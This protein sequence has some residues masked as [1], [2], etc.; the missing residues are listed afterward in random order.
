MVFANMSRLGHDDPVMGR[1][2]GVYRQ[3]WV[4]GR[5]GLASAERVL[6]VFNSSS[7]PTMV[8]KGM[9]LS[10]LYYPT[11][12][13][14]PMNDIDVLV[15]RSMVEEAR[16]ALSA[17]GWRNSLLDSY[18][19]N[20]LM[21]QLMATRPGIGLR[22]VLGR[23]VDLHWSPLHEGGRAEFT[24]WFWRCAEPMTLGGT[25]TLA[26]GPVR[27]LL[28]V[29]SHGLRPDGM[30][31]SRL[32]WVVDATMI[33]RR[34]GDDIDWA[35]FWTMARLARVE[36]RVSEGLRRL[37]EISPVILPAGARHY[38]R[39]SLIE[40]LERPLL[41]HRGDVSSASLSRRLMFLAS[42]LRVARC[43]DTKTFLSIARLRLS[44]GIRRRSRASS[45]P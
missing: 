4:R 45:V 9:A 6:K 14:R 43:V 23:E 5:Q 19:R 44:K 13:L 36:M 10:Q 40:L 25:N 32:Q 37:E 16:E 26:P 30:R 28:Q 15:P 22:D 29:I 42:T 34:A 27:L 20:G 24:A 8:T 38:A 35:E 31:M 2:R 17:N 18:A 1:L 12:T 3:S 33:L 11:A 21:P 7:I 39:P 41:A